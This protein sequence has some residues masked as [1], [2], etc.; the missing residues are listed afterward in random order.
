MRKLSIGLLTLGVVLTLGVLRALDL[1][2]ARAATLR[3]AEL[4]AANLARLTAAYLQESF[5]A[6]DASLRQLAIH[7]RR[8]GGPSAPA[9]EWSPILAAARAALTTTG[10]ISVVDGG[11]RIRHSTRSDILGQSRR[12]ESLTR[13]ALGATGDDLIVGTPF[14]AMVTPRAYII[15]IGRRLV[16]GNGRVVGAVVASFVPAEPRD[17]FQTIDVGRHGAV[18]VFHP[19]GVVLFHEPSNGDP[20]GESA[21][22][23]PIFAEAMRARGSGTLQAEVPPGGRVLV[24]AFHTTVTPPVVVAISLDRDEVLDAWVHEARTT[25]MVFAVMALTLIAVLRVLYRQMDAKAAAERAALEREQGARRA[26]EEA[27]ALKDQFLLTVSHELRTPLTAIAGWA[28]MLGEGAVSERQKESAL[29]IIERNALAQTRLVEDLLDVSH[30]M[31]GR[32]RLELRDTDIGDV[33]RGAVDTIRPAAEAKR[34]RIETAIEPGA[35]LVNGDPGRLEQIARNLLS[36][37]VKFTPEG[38]RI[39]VSAAPAEAWVELSV[40]DSGIGISPEFLP[41]VFDRFSQEDGGANRRYGG[42]GLGLAIVRHLVELHGGSVSA[43]S[44]GTG[45]GATFVVRLPA[46]ASGTLQAASRA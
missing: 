20:M 45:S 31:S 36:N 18:W 33:V 15:P 40:T 4:R 8:I 37:A 16:D 22:D 13:Q 29:R 38:G 19:E 12:S 23:N 2:A 26:A 44:N 25:G 42:L 32:L 5:E 14:P 3:T 24:S 46:A 35:R 10:A 30:A 39:V 41:H 9:A 27:N 17:F 11:G 28:R 43:R 6:A 21:Q 1:R 34:I 7:S